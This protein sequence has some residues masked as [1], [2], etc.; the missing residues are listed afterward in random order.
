MPNHLANE[1]SPYLLQHAHNPVDWYPWGDEALAKAREEQKPIFLSIG[2]TACHWCHVMERESFENPVT[3]QL[4]NAHFISIKVDREER[5]DL[6][7]IYM[8]AVV[9]M[10]GSGGWP[11]SVFLTPDLAPFYGGTYFPPIRRYNLPSFQEILMGVASAWQDDRVNVLKSAGQL[12]AHL[13]SGSEWSTPASNGLDAQTLDSAARS[14]STSIDSVHG[15]WGSAPKFPQPMAI[16]FLLQ[17]AVLGDANALKTAELSLDAMQRGGMYDLVGGGFHRYSTT[18]DWLVPHFEKMLYDN[19]Q[20]ARL[21]LHAWQI[22]A[23]PAYLR[24]CTQT[25]DFILREMR[26][27]EGG[28]FSSLDADSEG[29]EG[30]YYSW[31][32]PELGSILSDTEFSLLQAVYPL[33]AS[34]NFEG[35]IILQYPVDFKLLAAKLSTSQETLADQLDPIHAR[36]LAH[37]SQRTHPQ[38]DDKIITAWNGFTL[39]TLAEAARALNRPD[40]LAAAQAS[41]NFL[42]RELRMDG[43]LQRTWR[44]GQARNA[45]AL[46]DYAALILG[47][48]SL[49]QADF[50]PLWYQESV[51]LAEQMVARFSDPAGGF[52]DAPSDVNHLLI[53]PKNLQD[54]ATPSGSALAVM[55]LLQISAF[56]ARADWQH[57]AELALAPLQEALAQ[58][59]LAF[60]FWLQALRFAMGPVKQVAVVWSAGQAAPQALLTPFWRAYQP[61][62][63]LAGSPLPMTGSHPQLLNERP[64]VNGQAAVYVCENFTCQMPYTS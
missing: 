42:L 31:S 34:G 25:L 11:M 23:N 55:A 62:T 49:Y 22:T 12:T 27:P 46:E 21:Y 28:F 7:S 5:P 2:Y 26:H 40:Y 29:E 30:K 9:A 54:N 53:R 63:V 6:D 43:N 17:Q 33:P 10:T 59:P 60:S 20:L 58:H 50:N 37:R 39:K 4:L 3:A 15:G 8:N 52:F 36:L 1:T 35:K 51:G 13:R 47:L 14:L 44:S 32:L 16:E 48:L 61:L 41:A 18:A 24:T 57:L 19:A 56:S 45:A 38:T 64:L